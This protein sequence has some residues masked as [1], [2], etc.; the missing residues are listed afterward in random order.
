MHCAPADTAIPKHMEFQSPTSS[1]Q[2]GLEKGCEQAGGQRGK[3]NVLS[4]RF[5][6]PI[7][8]RDAASH[9]GGP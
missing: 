7:W 2:T 4:N 9:G 3:E 8:V 5:H 6:Q 1:T